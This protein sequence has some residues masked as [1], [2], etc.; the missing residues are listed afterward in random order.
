MRV[1]PDFFL[2][3]SRNFAFLKKLPLQFRAHVLEPGT[4]TSNGRW[5]LV[6][7]AGHELN[8]KSMIPLKAGEILLLE[9]ANEYQLRVIEKLA[10]DTTKESFTSSGNSKISGRDET[11][12]QQESLFIPETFQD[13]LTLFALKILN[14]KNPD[15][16]QIENSC[17]YFTLSWPEN[18]QGV[19][20]K[21]PNGMYDLFLAKESVEKFQ[22]DIQE[23]VSLFSDLPV[24]N[25][26]IVTESALQ[27]L[28]K[29]GISITG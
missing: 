11:H 21:K 7:I 10:D 14:E 6:K 25:V 22:A 26:Q 18:L 8:I 16:L 3:F 28:R 13:C 20:L 19:F 24:H 9:K 2:E 4:Q 17:Y 12:S 23:I 15:V 1:G 29:S 5:Y 27:N